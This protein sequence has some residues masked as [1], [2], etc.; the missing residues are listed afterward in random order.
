MLVTLR[1][2]GLLLRRTCL[3]VAAPPRKGATA[4]GEVRLGSKR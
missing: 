4:S 3:T 2:N 1:E